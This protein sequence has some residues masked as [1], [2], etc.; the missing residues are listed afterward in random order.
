MTR[1]L[2]CHIKGTNCSYAQGGEGASNALSCR[3]LFAKEPLILGLFCG[4]RPPE[5]RHP[6][7][8]RHPVAS[9]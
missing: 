3:S 6:V 2:S 4:K 8:L 5:I 7:G 9:V 1:L